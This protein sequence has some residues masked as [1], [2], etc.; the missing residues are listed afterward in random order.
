MI[1]H[2]LLIAMLAAASCARSDPVDDAARTEPFELDNDI[3]VQIDDGFANDNGD[4]ADA[5]CGS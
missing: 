2:L 5:E 3:V 1:R 4:C